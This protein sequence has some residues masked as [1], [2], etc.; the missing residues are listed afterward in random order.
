MA[1]GTF[2]IPYWCL[3]QKGMVLFMESVTKTLVPDK[4]IQVLLRKRFGETAVLLSAEE[5]K[6]G[7]FNACYKLSLSGCGHDALVLKTGVETGKYVLTYEQ[8]LM[9]T[10]VEVYKILE[11]TEIPVPRVIAADFS[12]QDINCDYFF[13]EHLSGAPWG[14]LI[15][16]EAL[17]PDNVDSLH[18]ELGRYTAL[19]H[20]IKGGYYGYIRED[21]FYRHPTWREAFRAM[22]D[23]VIQDG[24]R[25]KVDLPY[26]EIY[27]NLAPFWPLLDEI[28]EP[29][30]VHYD[31][32][33]KNIMLVERDG[34]YI[35]D[36]VIDLERCF[37]GDPVADYISTAT[38]VGD[39]EKATDFISGYETVKPFIFSLNDKIRLCMYHVYMGLLMGVEV[40]RYRGDDINKFITMSRGFIKHSLDNLQEINYKTTCQPR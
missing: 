37:Y 20:N 35:I 16:T 21:K 15:R 17:S 36:G 12:R 32:W 3:S 11:K 33:A 2:F 13:M 7:F 34:K 19:L 6:E 38:I 10:E 29:S 39:V 28:T 23:S 18:R 31:M 1:N 24:R 27:D 5:M 26:T 30:L 4:K 25:D 40:Y 14:S 8:G 22:V 9:Q